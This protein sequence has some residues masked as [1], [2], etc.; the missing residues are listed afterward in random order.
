M[1]PKKNRIS[2]ETTNQRPLVTLSS[3][4]NI[5]LRARK[6]KSGWSLFLDIQYQQRRINRYLNIHLSTV[7]KRNMTNL[8]RNL[9]LIAEQQKNQ[10]VVDIAAGKFKE[11]DD[12]EKPKSVLL[13]FDS[14]VQEKKD[15]DDKSKHKWRGAYNYFKEYSRKD[16]TFEDLSQKFLENYKLFLLKKLAQITARDYFNVLNSLLNTAVRYDLISFNPINKLSAKIS[17]PQSKRTFLVL[18]ELQELDNYDCP[19]AVTKKAFMFCCFSGLRYSDVKALKWSQ[20]HKEGEK[21]YFYF[22]Q[23]KTNEPERMPLAEQAMKYLSNRGK[24]DNLV[25]KMVNNSSTNGYL[26]K[27]L[28]TIN[29]GLQKQGRQTISKRITFHVARHTFATM[30]LNLGI[31]LKAVSTLLGHKD[32]NT[33]QIY[34]KII[35]KTKEEAVAKFPTF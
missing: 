34:A 4:S 24:A 29:E 18:E 2:E 32:I 3:S 27:W 30:A 15:R 21:Y 9:L 22:T 16:L 1:L 10:I 35:D 31:E 25:F 20:I 13:F 5:H 23:Q 26:R 14:M 6:N 8:D 19:H 7:E 28:K 33:T 11:N 12:Y 17:K